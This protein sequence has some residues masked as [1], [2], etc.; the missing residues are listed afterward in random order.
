VS[1]RVVLHVAKASGI[2]GSENHLLLL[3]PGLRSRGWDVRFLLLHESEPGAR[4]L[5]LRLEAVGVPVEAVRLPR[6]ASPTAFARVLRAVRRTRPEILHTHLVHAD[7]HGLVAGRLVGVPVLVST[8]HGFNPFRDARAFALADRTVARLADVHVAISHGLA[9]YLAEREGFRED[10]FAVVHYGI[11][12][13]PEPGPPEPGPRLAAV[14]RLIPIKGLDTLLDAVARAAV[15][16]L[17]LELA[18]DGP[19]RAEL[20][21]HAERVGLR[22]TVAF[23]GR[24]A[25]AGPVLERAAVVVV[26]SL[27][28]G[29]GMVALEAME[30]GRAVIVSA[31]GGLPEIVADGETGLLVPPGDADALAAAIR[32]LAADPAR[33]AAMGAAG[34]RRALE[35]FSQARCTEGIEALYEAALA[36]VSARPRRLRRRPHARSNAN[37]ASSASRKSQGTR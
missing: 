8:K 35:T 15:P 37:A 23:L 31:V 6:A 7:F 27:G 4:E 9:R 30:R 20:E 13:G 25:P 33:V 17:R 21:Q 34:R 28:E 16:G 22:E 2:S 5:A 24:V 32:E 19:L 36:E 10:A 14:G 1:E 29:F 3:L 26:P 18:G 11:E 12:P